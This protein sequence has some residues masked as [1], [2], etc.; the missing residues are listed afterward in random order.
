MMRRMPRRMFRKWQAFFAMEPWGALQETHERGTLAMLIHNKD[1]RNRRDAKTPADFF[2][3]LRRP[4]PL[5]DWNLRRLQAQ[6]YAAAMAARP[7]G[8][9]R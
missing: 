8:A 1:L 6:S 9:M 5:V 2:P 7:K 3:Q 4:K